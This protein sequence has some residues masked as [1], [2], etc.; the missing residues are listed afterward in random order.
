MKKQMAGPRIERSISRKRLGQYMTP[1]HVADFIANQL[2]VAVEAVVDLAAGDCALLTAVYKR[3]P[4]TILCGFEI[5]S[6]VFSVSSKTLPVAR[7]INADGLSTAIEK[8]NL[9]LTN[10]AVV[11]NPPFT[12]MEPTT[13]ALELIAK[14]FPSVTSKLG[15]KRSELYFLARSLLVAKALKGVVA[16]VMPIGFVDGDIYT[17][18]RKALMTEYAV[19]SVTEIPAQTF[20]FTEARTA[21]LVIDTAING[22][23]E[24]DICR[25]SA[26]GNE[27]LIIY[28]GPIDPGE[29]LD[30]RYHEGRL[31]IPTNVPTIGEMGVTITR[32]RVSRREAATLH[33][34]VIHTSSLR[35]ARHGGLHLSTFS[36]A[37]DI[38]SRPGAPILAE[39]GDILLPRTGTRVNWTPVIVRSG[40]GEI[41]DHIFRIRVPKRCRREVIASFRHPGFSS[42]LESI[43]KGVCATVLTKRE[44][45]LMPL[46]SAPNTVNNI[47]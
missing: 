24:V 28:R 19:K 38:V 41:T 5:D 34:D 27:T 44:L 23:T 4:D 40:S 1:N 46:F 37:A 17:Q 14:A 15:I 42:W 33:L 13:V 47:N 12:E 7:L 30:A 31:Q 2:P 22:S 16:V 36:P 21:L 8:F 26:C 6:G 25:Y 32:G 18:Y 29:R 39:P 3:N 20:S 45:L 10:V 43:S 9:P 11:G 35:Q